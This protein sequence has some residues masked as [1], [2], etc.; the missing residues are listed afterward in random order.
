MKFIN[1]SVIS[2]VPVTWYSQNAFLI[3]AAKSKQEGHDRPK[4]AHMSLLTKHEPSSFPV[5]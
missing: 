4:I 3:S 2:H 1:L 5:T